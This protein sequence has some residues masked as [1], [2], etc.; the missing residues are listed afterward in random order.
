MAPDGSVLCASP[1]GISVSKS[2]SNRIRIRVRERKRESIAG[3]RLN[4]MCSRNRSTTTTTTTMTTITRD[5]STVSR[6]QL[7]GAGLGE[8]S[9]DRDTATVFQHFSSCL[10]IAPPSL[11][12][13]LPD[14]SKHVSKSLSLSSISVSNGAGGEGRGGGRAQHAIDDTVRRRQHS[15]GAHPKRTRPEGNLSHVSISD[16]YSINATVLARSLSLPLAL[17]LFFVSPGRERERSHFLR[18]NR[19][20]NRTSSTR[21]DSRSL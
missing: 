14:R 8:L 10:K 6:M 13:L 17:F 16:L 3:E 9:R 15:F 20:T 21:M 11:P 1:N 12:V 19:S 5:V 4:R 2:G 7:K 18:A